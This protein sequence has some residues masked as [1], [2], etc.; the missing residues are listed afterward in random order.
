M[1]AFFPN[2][3]AVA[4]IQPFLSSLHALPAYLTEADAGA[5]FVEFVEA[6]LP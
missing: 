4:N 3:V 1:F 6:L 5:G 2:G